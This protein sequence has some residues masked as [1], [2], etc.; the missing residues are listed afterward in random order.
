MLYAITPQQLPGEAGRA[1]ALQVLVMPVVTELCVL[2]T[3]LEQSR[4]ASRANR[5]CTLLS[6]PNHC[7]QPKAAGGNMQ[8]LTPG[9][10]W[11]RA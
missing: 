5:D 10:K 6:A 4:C 8:Q 7:K 11:R 3:V 1:P 9:R 2:C